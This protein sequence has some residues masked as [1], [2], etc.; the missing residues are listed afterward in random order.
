MQCLSHSPQEEAQVQPDKKKDFIIKLL[1]NALILKHP[2]QQQE[3]H[4]T[5]WDKPRRIAN[6]LR[7]WQLSCFHFH[8]NLF[9]RKVSTHFH[10]SLSSFTISVQSFSDEGV[11]N[12]IFRHDATDAAKSATLLTA[13]TMACNMCLQARTIISC[14]QSDCTW[15]SLSASSTQNDRRK[16]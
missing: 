16:Y 15:G 9:K 10:F 2:M 4:Q 7:F 1:W 13:A 11:P 3:Q 12:N 8:P 6:F 14:I 5:L